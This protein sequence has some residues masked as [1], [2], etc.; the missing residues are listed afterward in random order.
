MDWERFRP[1]LK[2]ALKKAHKNTAGRTP[3]AAVL[4]FKMPV[5]QSLYNLSDDQ[6]EYQIRECFSFLRFLRLTPESAIPDAKTVWL[7]RESLKEP[8]AMDTLFAT[9]ERYRT[10]PGYQARKGTVVDARIVSVPKPRHSREA[11]QTIQD[12]LI[13]ADW[14]KQPTNLAQ[15][16]TEARCTGKHGKNYY[17][18][19]NHIASDVKHKLVRGFTV[20]PAS[21]HDSQEFETLRKVPSTLQAVWA[22]SACQSEAHAE[23]QKS[24]GLHNHLHDR[25]WREQTLTRAARRRNKRRS[26]I[27][28]RVEHVFGHQV[29]VMHQ[30]TLRSIGQARAEVKIGFANL[31]Y[32]MRR[33][34]H[35]ERCAA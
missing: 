1:V 20:T 23:L 17:G 8:Q 5:L 15:K 6:T 33:L 28:A 2:K 32:N 25:P 9:F 4:M 19:K 24:R 11:H 29:T 31:A 30:K 22:D 27:R 7:Y 13:P 34:G 16:D 21:T 18:Y 10:G 12:G 35:L 14:V 26:R 3:Y